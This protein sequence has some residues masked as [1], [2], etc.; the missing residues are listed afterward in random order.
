M[1]L[2]N[3]E[4]TLDL[5]LI[6]PVYNCEDYISETLDSLIEQC[7]YNIEIISIIYFV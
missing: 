6:I 3:R 4:Y 1:K 5:S 2:T 7:K